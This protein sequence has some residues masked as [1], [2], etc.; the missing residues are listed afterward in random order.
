MFR[1]TQYGGLRGFLKRPSAIVSLFG[2]SAP[3]CSPQVK[4]RVELDPAL[5]DLLRD[6]DISLGGNKRSRAHHLPDK[7]ELEEFPELRPDTIVSG[8]VTVSELGDFEVSEAEEDAVG[9]KSPAADFG[10]RSI[11]AVVLP[12]ELQN[13][14]NLIIS[15]ADILT[16]N[17]SVHAKLKF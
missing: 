6:V 2:S 16:R 7:R 5:R 3:A 4:P 11:G 10:S 15:G 13:S 12:L 8:G 9:R 1:A 14:I 17:S